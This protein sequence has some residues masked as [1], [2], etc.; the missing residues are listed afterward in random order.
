MGTIKKKIVR[1]VIKK[2]VKTVPKNSEDQAP[3]Q[4]ATASLPVQK[5][6][7]EEMEPEKPPCEQVPEPE[8]PKT[9]A[10]TANSS[11][12]QTQ[13]GKTSEPKPEDEEPELDPEAQ[14]ELNLKFD[15]ELKRVYSE[16]DKFSNLLWRARDTFELVSRRKGQTHLRS[17]TNQEQ[18]EESEQ[19]Q[20]DTK[21]T[22]GY[23]EITRVSN[24]TK[25]EI[26]IFSISRR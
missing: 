24:L 18:R 14:M 16:I 1:K 12:N 11:N 23:G 22:V 13:S 3:P 7:T 4:E 6:A 10:E 21:A 9:A 8:E 19:W 15:K 26:D 25:R 5:P 2:I 17:E 20:R